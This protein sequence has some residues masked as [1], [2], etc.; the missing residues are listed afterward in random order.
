MT[1]HVVPANE[2]DWDAAFRG[3]HP[4]NPASEMS[5]IRL[6]EMT[7]LKRLGVNLIRIPPGKESFIPHA[8]TV[9]EE[10]VFVI[11]GVGAV[12]LDGVSHPIGPGDY[13]GFPTDGVV[14]NLVNTGQSDLLYLTVGERARAEVADMPTI[15]KTTIFRNNRMTLFGPDGIEELS[16][17]EWFARMQIAPPPEG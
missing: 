11:E 7:G 17:E 10:M 14:H 12:V 5:M 4:F 2:L 13:V 16:A 15:G 3:R 1:R 8:H 6:G 9:E